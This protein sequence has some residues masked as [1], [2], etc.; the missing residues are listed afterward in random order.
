MT[1]S[2]LVEEST[3]ATFSP[4]RRWRYRLW[5][6]WDDSLPR[7]LFCLMNPS[8]ADEVKNDPTVEAQ[9]RRVMKWNE[10]KRWGSPYGGVE[11]VN[12]F[13]WR[14]TD[15]KRLKGLHASGTDIVG[16]ENDLHIAQAASEA[17]IVVCGW[18]NPANL[19]GRG[20]Q[21][22]RILLEEA[23]GRLYALGINTDGTP[24]HPL[25]IG[26]DAELV[27]L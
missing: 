17:A 19:A 9:R 18:G 2:L 10:V 5:R 16:P 20:D 11:V 26:Y 25:Y 24:Q 14:E 13:A 1:A 7:V 23:A 8:T 3:G 21:V 4:C 15:S 27:P 6:V 12:A 22:R